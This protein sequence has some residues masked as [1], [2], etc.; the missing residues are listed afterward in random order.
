MQTSEFADSAFSNVAA[1]VYQCLSAIV[2]DR[3]GYKPKSRQALLVKHIQELA[4]ISRICWFQALY[5]GGW[6]LAT[7]DRLPT[8]SLVLEQL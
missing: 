3:H 5:V 8:V 6:G 2:S 1:N 4:K 7:I